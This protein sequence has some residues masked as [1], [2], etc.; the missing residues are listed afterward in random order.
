MTFKDKKGLMQQNNGKQ[1]FFK[2]K[3]EYNSKKCDLNF[4]IQVNLYE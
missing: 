1:L 2:V 4:S 3:N